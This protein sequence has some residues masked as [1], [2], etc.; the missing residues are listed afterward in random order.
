[1]SR[2]RQLG[3]DIF[4]LT[5]AYWTSE[6]WWSAW[7]FLAAVIALNLGLVYI[8]LQQNLATG[9]VFTALQQRNYDDFRDAF[10]VLMLLILI[11]LA[12]AVLRV[13]LQQTLE[14]RWRRWLTDQYL[15]RWLAD[16]NF[17]RMRFSGGVDNP[18]QR[19]SEDIRLY[20]EQTMGL[21][22][23]LLNSAATLASFA[24]LLWS[25][26]GALTF[27]LDGF[28]LVVPGYM[29]WAA[30]LYAG[31]GSFLAHLIGHPLIRLNY[32]QQAAEADFR[33]ALVRLREEAEGIALYGGEAQER[34]NALGRFRAL[35]EN[36]TQLIR[37][38]ARYVLFQLMF[39]QFAYG[40]SLLAASPRYFSGAIE[41]GPLVQISNA[42]ERV[43]EALSWF[44]GSY[45]VFAEWR[46]TVTRL[47]ELSHVLTQESEQASAGA[48]RES[49]SADGIE[50]RDLSVALPDGTPLIAPATL[51]LEPHQAVLLRGRSGSGKTTL[52]RVL[53]GL[54]TFAAGRLRMPAHAKMLFLPQQPYMPI[55]GL[56]EAL[57]YPARPAMRRDPEARAALA[58]V[59]LP[60]LA[61]RLDERAHWA[62][63]LSEGEQQ[64]LAI[65]RAML[66]RPEWLFIDEATS[67]VDEEQEAALYRA[68]FKALPKTTVVSIGHRRE[69]EAFHGRI[70]NLERPPGQP[71]RL[72]D[73]GELPTAAALP[74]AAS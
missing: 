47:T 56:R 15:A 70:I 36:F 11:Y 59:G 62:Q 40:F 50:L 24:T 67:A 23:G 13:F 14:L 26:S 39:S 63:Q 7:A 48:R 64:R 42:F 33:F 8:N 19:I 61:A 30:V 3:G 68:L 55:G 46:A 44:I 60:E 38:N 10:L 73:A 28:V 1:M 49:M 35:Y 6:E 29:F 66:T 69:L 18:D 5:K 20:I 17:Y 16:R 4:D 2:L 25:L 51:R 34:G 65:A 32:R 72:V 58:A 12:V 74:K 21:G 41:L 43:N 37:F 31:A 52:F 9:G 27:S 22:L 54:W 57:W 71:T 53:A 45:A